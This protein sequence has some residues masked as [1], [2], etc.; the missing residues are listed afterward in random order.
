MNH[1]KFKQIFSDF[2][3]D[4]LISFPELSEKLN[5]DDSETYTYC[6]EM[7]PKMFFHDFCSLLQ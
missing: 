7:Y 5:L 4:L 1:E 3:K 6:S 2:K